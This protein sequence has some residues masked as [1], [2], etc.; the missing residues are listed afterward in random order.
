M[1]HSIYVSVLVGVPLNVFDKL[2]NQIPITQLIEHLFDAFY[3]TAWL[4]FLGQV[5]IESTSFTRQEKVI[6]LELIGALLNMH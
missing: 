5:F 6:A 1:L 3:D 4:K 2:S